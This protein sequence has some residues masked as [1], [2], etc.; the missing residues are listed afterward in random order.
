MLPKFLITLGDSKPLSE[1]FTFIYLLPSLNS[2]ILSLIV[3]VG[4][5]SKLAIAMIKE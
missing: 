3:G 1:K 5:R 2:K 4:S